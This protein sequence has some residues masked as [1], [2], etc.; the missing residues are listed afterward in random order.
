MARIGRQLMLHRGALL[1]QA[2]EHRIP[3]IRLGLLGRR[4]PSITTRPHRLRLA[5]R[6]PETV[7]FHEQFWTPAAKIVDIVL[8]ATTGLERDDIGTPGA[9]PT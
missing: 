5:W 3:D 7:V 8:P 1:L 2:P 4:N 9:S 6:S